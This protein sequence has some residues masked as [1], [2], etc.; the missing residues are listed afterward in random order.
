MLSIC[1]WVHVKSTWLTLNPKSKSRHWIEMAAHFAWLDVM[2]RRGCALAFKALG[3]KANVLKMFTRKST[4]SLSH[5]KELGKSVSLVDLS[6][7]NRNT[8]LF[9]S[10]KTTQKHIYLIRWNKNN[11]DLPLDVQLYQMPGKIK[12]MHLLVLASCRWWPRYIA[13]LHK[14][15]S[16]QISWTSSESCMNTHDIRISKSMHIKKFRRP[17]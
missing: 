5:R 2:G 12:C 4:R 1:K 8:Q 3:T 13:I 7:L 16:A 14:S 9:H 17:F 10:W 15:R 6:L 11:A